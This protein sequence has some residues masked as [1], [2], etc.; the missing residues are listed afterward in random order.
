MGVLKNIQ[1]VLRELAIDGE[2]QNEIRQCRRY[3]HAHPELSNQEYDTTEFIRE[4]LAK[5]D[6]QIME[7]TRPL[8]TGV[9]A[10]IV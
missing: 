8:R 1:D 5:L 7:T 2:F 3:L 9:I 4:Q 10:F 6:I